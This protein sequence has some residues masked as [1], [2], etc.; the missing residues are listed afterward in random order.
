MAHDSG[1]WPREVWPPRPACL[2]A[3]S[4]LA[5]VP[6]RSVGP[7]HAI[8]SPASSGPVTSHHPRGTH[9]LTLPAGSELLSVGRGWRQAPM[10][11]RE[12]SVRPW[13]CVKEKD[14]Q[15]S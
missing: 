12:V 8:S 1:T 4:L 5:S 9:G 3:G 11:S 13:T 14:L 6:H 10:K 7:L 2:F 15:L